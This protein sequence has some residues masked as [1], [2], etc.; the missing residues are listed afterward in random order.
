MTKVGLFGFISSPHLHVCIS[1]C[2]AHLFWTMKC[3]EQWWKKPHIIRIFFSFHVTFEDQLLKLP[4]CLVAHLCHFC[5]R[6]RMMWNSY[7]K[8]RCQNREKNDRVTYKKIILWYDFRHVRK[9][10]IIGIPINNQKKSL[11][12]SRERKREKTKPKFTFSS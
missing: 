6:I 7:L 11:T 12:G 8:Q 4:L 2:A 1:H 10:G 3:L 5:S 9:N